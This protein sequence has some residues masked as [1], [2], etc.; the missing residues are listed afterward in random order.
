MNDNTEGGPEFNLAEARFV[1]ELRQHPELLTRF[2]SILELTRTADGPVQT[3]Y[4]VE[5]RL[6]LELRQLGHTT[7]NH[8]ATQAEQHVSDELK[9]A[10]PTVRSRKKNADMVVRLWVGARAGSGLAQSGY[11]LS[12]PLAR[13]LGRHVRRT[14]PAAGPGVDGLW[15]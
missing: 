5:A 8:W 13:A 15:Q 6:I 2:Q 7:M 9:G 1:A 10:D 3:A 11:E 14:V 4:A 12:A